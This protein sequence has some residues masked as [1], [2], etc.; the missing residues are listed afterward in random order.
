MGD[1]V[2]FI[3]LTSSKCEKKNV[4]FLGNDNSNEYYTSHI[5]GGYDQNKRQ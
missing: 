5:S 1:S 3:Q 2:L 4:L